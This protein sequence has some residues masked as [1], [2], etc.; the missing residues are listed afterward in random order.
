VTDEDLPYWLYGLT[1]RNPYQ[2]RPLDPYRRPT[3]RDC[4]IDIGFATLGHI[5]G[6][7]QSAAQKEEPAFVVIEG[8]EDT[9]R[10]SVANYLL[11]KYFEFRGVGD[12]HVIAHVDVGDYDEYSWALTAMV[13]L[14]N[15]VE[16]KGLQL[17]RELT[18][19]LNRIEQIPVAAYKQ[20]FQGI[21]RTLS[22]QLKKLDEPHAFGVLFE[23]VFKPEFIAAAQI[24]FQKSPAL[25]TFTHDTYKHAL[26]AA[27]PSLDQAR[28][29]EEVEI[30]RLGCLTG[31]QVCAL[32]DGRWKKASEL[33]FP[34]DA[35]G[36]GELFHDKSEPIKKV[37]G[38]LEEL[39]NYKL[40]LARNEKV[41]WPDNKGLE[42]DDLWLTATF[43]LIY[44]P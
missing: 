32:A 29:D 40:N 35:N 36:L 7:L 37:M 19:T 41:P 20:R 23:K 2:T 24:I 1:D 31:S 15:E 43:P 30:V 27:S 18:D 11:D 21:A 28:F 5:L 4:W 16:A 39:L 38:W 17:A 9:G 13:D 6:R 12:R 25:I 44:K 42:M 14:Q 26:T 22:V 3:D 34:F 10:T 33:D 8:R